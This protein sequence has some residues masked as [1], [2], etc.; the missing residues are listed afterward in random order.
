[1]RNFTDKGLII[2]PTRARYLNM[3]A[4]ARGCFNE[5]IGRL[6]HVFESNY[7]I[8][9]F[10]LNTNVIFGVPMPDSMTAVFC[11]CRGDINFLNGVVKNDG[12]F[13]LICDDKGQF[14]PDE[15]DNIREKVQKLYPFKRGIAL[16]RRIEI[17]E[18]RERELARR[19]A[20]KFS[21]IISFET[22][23]HR[24]YNLTS[25]KNDGRVIIEIEPSTMT[26]KGYLSGEAINMV[27]LMN[28]DWAYKKVNLWEAAL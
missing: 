23:E 12:F 16:D 6:P 18:T 21:L 5:T 2:F 20:Q 10:Y 25:K 17:I 11:L 22:D 4:S 9:L 3:T 15:Y 24:R 19:I 1:M 8:K 14:I 13:E 26:A 7:G 28:K 27:S